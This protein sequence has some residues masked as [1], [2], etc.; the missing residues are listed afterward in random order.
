MTGRR[1]NFI[2]LVGEDTGLHHGCY[3]NAYASTPNIDRLAERGARYT[4][5]V[6]TAPVCSPSRCTM[7][8][9]CYP[10]S[11]GTHHHRSK[12]LQPPRLVTEELRDAGYYVNWANKTDFNFDPPES[13]ADE[14]REWLDDLA[15]AALPDRPFL[16]FH[17]FGVTHESTMWRWHERSGAFEERIRQRH[18]LADGQHHDPADAPV[19]AYLPDAPEVRGDIA[20]YFDALSVQDAQVGDVLAA[21]ERSPCRDNTYVLYLS[22]HGRGLIRE[23]RWCYE[24]GLHLPLIVTGPGVEPGSVVDDV[25]SWVDLAPTILSLAG[26]TAPEHY[27]GRPFIGPDR[28]ARDNAFAGRG[29]MDETYDSVRA[30]R[31]KD[32]L[33]IRNDHPELAYAQLNIYEQIQYTTQVTRELG[34]RKRLN[35][36]A[37]SWLQPT[38]P[39]E[40]LYNIHNDPD[41]VTDLS[42]APSRADVLTRMRRALAEHRETVEDLGRLPERELIARG[43]VADVLEAMDQRRRSLDDLFRVGA[44]D[45]CVMEMPR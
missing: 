3:G 25:V 37:A 36:P 28:V 9:G 20:R 35:G 12:L 39:D 33:Y 4:N 16:L 27:Q 41:C 14:R 31:N 6:S 21:L 32:W 42:A 8:T 45:R 30:V 23:K 40:E 38:K 34:A 17:N 22:D 2:V 19:P 43:L 1:P 15:N 7:V 11:I 5:A 26:V 24:A 10:W 44:N 13:F 29:R 18:R